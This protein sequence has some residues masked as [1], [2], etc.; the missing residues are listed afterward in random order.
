M[1]V[2]ELACS[3]ILA[4]HRKERLGGFSGIEELA[5]D[6]IVHDQFHELDPM[7]LLHGM[8]DATDFDLDAAVHLLNHRH[9]LLLG[10]VYGVLGEAGHLLA[11]ANQGAGTSVQDFDDIAASFA[12]VDFQSLCH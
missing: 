5:V 11:T 4:F 9:V 3:E 8:G 1:Q 10:G 12:F 7:F 2:A 6:L